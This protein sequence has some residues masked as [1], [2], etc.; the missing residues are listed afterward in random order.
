MRRRFLLSLSLA[1]MGLPNAALSADSD[2]DTLIRRLARPVPSQVAFTEVRFSPLLKDALVVAGQLSYEGPASLDRS[3]ERPYRERTQI[4]GES[5]RVARE[6]EPARSFALKRSPELRGLLN[7][8]VALLSGDPTSLHGAFRATLA[9][10]VNARW[11]L[12]L[13]PIDARL[14]KRLGRIAIDGHG[15]NVRC[16]STATTDGGSSVML[17]GELAAREW[18]TPI[19]HSALEK[20][21]TDDPAASNR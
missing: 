1:L 17:F 2:V 4:R 10:D 12:E 7:G 16:F 21:C 18:P 20:H 8:F 6:G 19:T 3:V 14:A 9:G 11:H 15:E 5:V 13:T